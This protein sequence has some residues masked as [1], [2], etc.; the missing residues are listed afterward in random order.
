MGRDFDQFQAMDT[1]RTWEKEFYH[2]SHYQVNQQLAHDDGLLRENLL[3]TSE[4]TQK[5]QQKSLHFTQTALKEIADNCIEFN[6]I[7][8]TNQVIYIK[9]ISKLSSSPFNSLIFYLN[10][11]PLKSKETTTEIM[12]RY[13]EANL[14]PYHYVKLIGRSIGIQKCCP[15]VYN[16]IAYIPEKGPSNAPV[17]WYALHHV[18]HAIKNNQS[19]LTFLHFRNQHEFSLE[20]GKKGYERQLVHVINLYSLQ[21]LFKKRIMADFNLIELPSAEKEL[22][23]IQKRLQT[24]TSIYLEP[25]SLQQF[26]NYLVYFKVQELLTKVLGEENPFIEEIMSTFKRPPF[27]F[28]FNK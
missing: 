9:D 13:F 18:V 14:V 17:S 4:Y 24:A 7:V 12:N 19:N 22:N 10:Q 23:V 25:H 15:Y 16:T 28:R 11:E 8:I 5:G 6:H 20:L 26:L 27:R 1:Y 3:S 21:Q 2:S